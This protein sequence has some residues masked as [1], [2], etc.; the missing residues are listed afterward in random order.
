ML[1]YQCIIITVRPL[2][3][4]LLWERLNCFKRGETPRAFSTPVQTLV[5]ACIDS[6]TKSLKILTAVRDYNLLGMWSFVISKGF[7][8]YFSRNFPPFRLGE[9]FLRH[10]YI[11]PYIGGLPRGAP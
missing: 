5:K 8:T 4:N 11:G 7:Q 1:T 9:Y 10:I 6:A 3:L 2:V